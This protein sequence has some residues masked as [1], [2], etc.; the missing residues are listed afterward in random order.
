MRPAPTC[1]SAS[2]PARASCMA[3]A[4]YCRSRS[5]CRRCRRYWSIPAWRCRPRQYLPDGT[6]RQ[7]PFLRLDVRRSCQTDEAGSSSC[8]CWRR[9]RTIWRRLQFRCSRSSPKCSPRCADMPNAA[10]P[11]CPAPALPALACSPLPQPPSKAANVLRNKHPPWWV[12]PT[13]LGGKSLAD[14]AN[15]SARCRNRPFRRAP[16]SSSSREIAPARRGRWRR[17]GARGRSCL[18]ARGAWS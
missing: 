5:S 10:W 2:I 3:S 16:I 15:A 17:N 11:A 8:S 18:R 1:R 13:T 9:K 7:S 6:P 14:E 12:E 4:K